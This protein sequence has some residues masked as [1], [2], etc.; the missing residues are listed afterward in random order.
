[1]AWTVTTLDARVDAELDDLP[2]DMRARFNRVANLIAAVGLQNV[3]EPHVKHIEGVLWEMRMTGRDGI[4][5]ALYVTEVG[6]RV[7]VLRVFVKKT[8]KTPRREID[9]ALARMREIRR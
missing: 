5:R 8:Q 2:V 4:S 7:V 9:I 3:H 1:M 6:E